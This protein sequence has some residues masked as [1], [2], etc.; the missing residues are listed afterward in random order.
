M[1]VDID[2]SPDNSFNYVSLMNSAGIFRLWTGHRID[3]DHINNL[4]LSDPLTPEVLQQLAILMSGFDVDEYRE[5]Y[6][7]SIFREEERTRAINSV[8]L[9][10]DIM[11]RVRK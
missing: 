2:L 4:K 10:S 9:P 11:E 3:D 1:S 5:L 6:N 8:T 7:E